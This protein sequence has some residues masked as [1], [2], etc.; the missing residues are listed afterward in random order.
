MSSKPRY[1]EEAT[2]KS[3][4]R[5]NFAVLPDLRRAAA[6]VFDGVDHYGNKPDPKGQPSPS[7]VA[8][9]LFFPWASLVGF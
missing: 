5:E 9:A 3:F 8:V 6:G 7:F 1:F 4:P 2:C